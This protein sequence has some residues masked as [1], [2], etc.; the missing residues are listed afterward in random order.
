MPP[1]VGIV[2]L[3]LGQHSATDSISSVIIKFPLLIML[4]LILRNTLGTQFNINN[5]NMPP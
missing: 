5:N 1:I 3:N 4:L 2:G